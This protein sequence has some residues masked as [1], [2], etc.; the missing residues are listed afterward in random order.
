MI[1]LFLLSL[2]RALPHGIMI[3][4]ITFPAGIVAIAAWL[5][6]FLGLFLLLFVPFLPLIVAF[7]LSHAVWVFAA[8]LAGRLVGMEGLAPRI[9]YMEGYRRAFP[10]A[11]VLTLIIALFEW[12]VALVEWTGTGIV[13]PEDVA[14]TLALIED[15]GTPIW[16]ALCSLLMAMIL[17]P[18]VNGLRIRSGGTHGGKAMAL[19]LFV[20]L[21]VVALL[22]WLATLPL[23]LLLQQSGLSEQLSDL[24][25]E[26]FGQFL[27]LISVP[28]FYLGALI[29]F[30]AALFL[31][32]EAHFV[33]RLEAQYLADRFSD[34]PAEDAAD[35]RALRLQRSRDP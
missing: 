35:V 9:D 15:W 24:A 21:P 28:A 1:R 23:V 6:I 4:L 31:A 22:T 7:L 20:G 11:A 34:E 12:T 3:A 18:L 27:D 29:W 32:F 14:A 26:D 5:V 33:A 25:R 16:E 30:S 2:S 10:M 19:R 17:V 8:R 13:S